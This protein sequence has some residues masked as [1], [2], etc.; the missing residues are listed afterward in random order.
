MSRVVYT[1]RSEKRQERSFR[2]YFI[3]AGI[4]VTTLGAAGGII[5]ALVHPYVQISEVNFS[6]TSVL[7][8]DGLRRT[9][10][11][12]LAGFNFL[13]VPKSSIFVANTD[14]LA[15]LLVY[16][17]PRIKQIAIEKK[18]PRTLAVSVVERI[19]W[20]IACEKIPEPEVVEQRCVYL[21]DEG[22]GLESAPKSTGGLIRKIQLE[23]VLPEPGKEL[24][25]PEL[26][27]KMKFLDRLLSES[28]GS[29]IIEFAYSKIVPREISVRIDKGYSLIFSLEENFTESVNVLKTVLVKEIGDKES[30]LEYIDL[31]FGN[32]VFF[33]LKN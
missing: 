13:V 8:E 6:G 27:G 11:E 33:K 24:V 10:K 15:A 28:T 14:S 4:L 30:D 32:K 9:I 5:F 19:M 23:G 1:V 22:Y 18:F 17:N 7:S 31:R 25:P 16:Q 29:R 21:D 20:G 3:F 26:V 12:N 2:K